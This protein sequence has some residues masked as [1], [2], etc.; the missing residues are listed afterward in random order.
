[1]LHQRTQTTPPLDAISTISRRWRIF[2]SLLGGHIG[3]TVCVDSNKQ[4]TSQHTGAHYGYSAKS[5]G[6]VD[7]CQKQNWGWSL[8]CLY[9]WCWWFV[10]TVADW[11]IFLLLINFTLTTL[12]V[13]VDQCCSPRGKSCPGSLR[14]NLQVLVL[15]FGP[16]SPWK[17]SRTSHSANSPLCMWRP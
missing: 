11:T 1:M 15:V 16:Q 6:H 8:K 4:S 3:A 17:F 13:S 5:D 14:T 12:L 10:I 7:K 9:L 2:S